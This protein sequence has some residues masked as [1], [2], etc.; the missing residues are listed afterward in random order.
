MYLI[1][2]SNSAD[3]L[4]VAVDK[5]ILKGY[6]CQ[7]GVCVSYNNSGFSPTYCQAMIIKDESNG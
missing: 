5:L 6:V 2:E 1:L 4:C 3:E 7:G